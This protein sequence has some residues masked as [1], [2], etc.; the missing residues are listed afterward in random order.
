MSPLTSGEKHVLILNCTPLVGCSPVPTGERE[1]DAHF[2]ENGPNCVIW[3]DVNECQK[4]KKKEDTFSVVISWL[5]LLST[6]ILNWLEVH[7]NV[8]VIVKG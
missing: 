3:G 4:K 6:G 2:M 1:H 7:G 8:E 5:S